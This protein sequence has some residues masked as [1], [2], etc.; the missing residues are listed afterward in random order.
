MLSPSINQ[1][2]NN[3]GK[4]SAVSK[5]GDNLF[6]MRSFAGNFFTGNAVEILPGF[7]CNNSNM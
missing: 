5:K 6:R 7:G 4:K 3:P 2:I 1:Y